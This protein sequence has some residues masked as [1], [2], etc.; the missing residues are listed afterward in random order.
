MRLQTLAAL[1]IEVSGYALPRYPHPLEVRSRTHPD[2]PT[3]NLHL[4]QAGSTS[5][6][7][8]WW[9]TVKPASLNTHALRRNLAT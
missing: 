6:F 3:L 4:A 7:P 9:K 8:G 5:D 1:S 2:G